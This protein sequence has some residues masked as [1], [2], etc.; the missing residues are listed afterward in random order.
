VSPLLGLDA[1]INLEMTGMLGKVLALLLLTHP[2]HLLL[3]ARML[4]P[5]MVLVSG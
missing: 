5:L 2:N 4:A 1:T 3:V